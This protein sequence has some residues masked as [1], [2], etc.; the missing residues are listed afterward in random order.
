MTSAIVIIIRMRGVQRMKKRF[1]FLTTFLILVFGTTMT[2]NAKPKTMPDGTVFDAE[3]YASTYAD[4]KEAFGSDEEALYNHYVQN[5]KAE[6]R[7]ACDP[8]S[9]TTVGTTDALTDNFDAKYYAKNNPDVVK[10]LGND[11]K[12]L[13]QHYLDHG[14]AEGRLPNSQAEKK[15]TTSSESNTNTTKSTASKGS[16]SVTVPK[17]NEST[18]TLVWV[19]TKGGTKYHNSSTCS[20][21]KGPKHVSIETAKASG[22]TACKKCYK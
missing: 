19:P 14:K 22:Y 3:Y 16:T 8:Y 15:T 7:L 20:K 21:M 17:Q 11:E 10:A 9:N 2:V 6:G 18:G 4:V 12:V 1:L 5:G 13:Y